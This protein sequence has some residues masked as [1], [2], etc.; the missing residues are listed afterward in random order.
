MA[1]GLSDYA[2]QA[3]LNHMFRPAAG[4]YTPGASNYIALHDGAPGD[5]GANEVTGGSYGRFTMT[6]ATSWEAAG[7]VVARTIRN[8]VVVS[9]TGMPAT[10]VT[11]VSVW[12]ASTNGNCLAVDALTASKAVS[13]G[14]TC[15]FAVD[16]LR[17]QFAAGVF[18]D[19]LA[20]GWLD[21]MFR[22]QS[23][24]RPSGH[25]LMIYN[26]DPTGAGSPV[27]GASL[28]SIAFNAPAVSGDRYDIDQ[29]GAISFASLNA[30]TCDYWLV[31]DTEGTP[32]PL[33]YRNQ[34]SLTLANGDDVDFADQTVTIGV[35]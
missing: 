12:D 16:V 20:E 9:F 34:A 30:D 28:Q 27:S 33:A 18:T 17:I 5:T 6:A 4:A 15:E 1:F 14:G 11:H 26:G 19:Y 23:L 35:D 3:L 8:D 7:S 24:T 10:T 21:F 13:S 31:Q 22:N 29:N 2:E 25:N 32:N